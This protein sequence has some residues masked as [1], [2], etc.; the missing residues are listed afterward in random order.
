MQTDG[1]D[2]LRRAL[3]ACGDEV[4]TVAKLSNMLGLSKHEQRVARDRLNRLVKTGEVEKVAYG[5]FRYR[6]DYAPRRQGESYV[7]LWRLIRVQGPGWS[8]AKISA[9]VRIGRTLVD[10]YVNYLEDKGFVERCGREGNT[11]LWRTTAKGREQRET[12]Y[13]PLDIP[14]D[15]ERER[16]ATARLCQLMLTC[17]PDLPSTRMR[18]MK[19]L[20]I[21]LQSF[22]GQ[23]ENTE[24]ESHV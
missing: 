21:L 2:V 10:N 23:Y 13:P 14:D 15:Y 20:E 1:M 5:Q 16:S 9:L 24:G 12:P 11:T 17:N 3:R 8:R 4:V 18:I 22:S 19:Q 7:R 6:M